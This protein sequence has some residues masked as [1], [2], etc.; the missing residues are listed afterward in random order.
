MA[1]RLSSNESPF[2]PLRAVRDAVA[3]SAAHINRYPSL[4]PFELIDLLAATHGV[5]AEQIVVGGGSLSVLEQFIRTFAGEGDEVI[6]GWR[7]YEAY[8]IVVGASGARA[9]EVNLR[10]GYHDLEEMF[11]RITDAT[12]VIIV[13]NPNNPTGTVLPS[14]ALDSF[15]ARVPGRCLIVLDEAYH[16]FAPFGATRDGLELVARYPN[17]VVLRTFS[18]AYGLAGLRVGYAVA[19]R[20][21]IEAVTRIELPFSVSVPAA[22]AASAALLCSEEIFAQVKQIQIER[23]RLRTMLESARLR[24]YPSAANFLWLPMGADSVAFSERCAHGGVAVRCFAGEGVRITVGT[25]QSTAALASIV[26]RDL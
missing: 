22:A 14:G 19:S 18:K 2:E 15:V 8:P 24:V 26:E 5:A 21:V 10:D 9:V 7:S 25:A 16:E 4:R 23:E 12:R 20:A 1:H 6:Y 13:C 17:V 3:A 11:G